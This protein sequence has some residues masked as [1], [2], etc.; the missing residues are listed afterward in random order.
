MSAFAV[1]PFSCHTRTHWTLLGPARS[2]DAEFTAMDVRRGLRLGCGVAVVLFVFA[3]IGG[4]IVGSCEDAREEDRAEAQIAEVGQLAAAG[5]VEEAATL[6]LA[7][8]DDYRRSDA[9]DDDGPLDAVLR[10]FSAPDLAILSK[11]ALVELP[12]PGLPPGGESSGERVS[13]LCD[14]AISAPTRMPPKRPPRGNASSCSS[15]WRPVARP[16]RELPHLG[17]P[18]FAVSPTSRTLPSS[19]RC[20]RS[21]PAPNIRGSRPPRCLRRWESEG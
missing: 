12:T 10:K 15:A 8:F 21:S 20:S 2:T 3:A 14:A 18:P 16:R 11:R 17:Q 4:L 7:T 19:K 1:G 6:F 5:K 13:A 9:L